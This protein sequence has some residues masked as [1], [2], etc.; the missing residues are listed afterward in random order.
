MANEWVKVELFGANNDGQP[1][2]YTIADSIAVSKG[3]LMNLIDSRAVSYAG[4][5]GAALAGVASE[6]KNANDGAT[7]ISCWTQ[8]I[9]RV[10]ASAAIVLGTA[11][12]SAAGTNQNQIITSSGVGAFTG[13]WVLDTTA[14]AETVNVRLN[15]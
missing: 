2:R 6:S 12:E 7:T 13:G 9:F 10:L 11:W 8:G 4:A 15:L 1:V 3:T 5:A 14:T